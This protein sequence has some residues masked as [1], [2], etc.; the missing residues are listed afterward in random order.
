MRYNPIFDYW[1]AVSENRKLRQ[2][3][4]QS[5]P[6]SVPENPS[7]SCPF[8]EGH[9]HETPHELD[10]MLPEKSLDN[11]RCPDGPGWM[12]RA[13]PNRFPFVTPD[14]EMTLQQMGPHICAPDVGRQEV[15]VDVPF[16]AKSPSELNAEEFQYLIYFYHRRMHQARKSGRWRYVQLFKNQGYS[17]GA[18]ISHIHS[19]AAALPFVPTAILQEQ[20]F[21]RG[22]REQ[23][24]RCY[25]CEV[26]DFERTVGWRWVCETEFFAAFCPFASRFPG[27]LHILPKRHTPCFVE[28]QR[29]ELDD[30][31]ILLR[32]LLHDFER[33]FS[34]S[35]YNLVFKNTP[36]TYDAAG[37][38]TDPNFH[39][40][41]EIL[42][43]TTRMA[44][45]EFGTGC[46][47]NQMSPETAAKRWM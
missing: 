47:V 10:A 38:H 7:C 35:C 42:P 45:F 20:T 34:P 25:H 5:N 28:S 46:Y 8:C 37:V 3:D 41:L 12:I 22:Y 16:H 4:F 43:R 17:A 44:G 29:E 21:L 40:R 15:I 39:W 6:A 23:N 11:Y 24:Q 13:V 33:K 30:L 19:Q 1:V 36:W 14:N 18:S 32:R 27:E 26:L 2:N 31:A 9:E